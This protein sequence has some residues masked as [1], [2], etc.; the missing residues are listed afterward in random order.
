MGILDSIIGQA[1][2]GGGGTQT[3]LVNAVIGLINNQQTG[4]LAGLVKQF[5]GLGLGDI[6]N[7]WVSTGKNLPV[8][9]QQIQQG[10]G[11]DAI[12]QLAAKVGLSPQDLTLHLSNVL[13]Q[14]VDKL[15]PDGKIPQGDLM[16]KGMSILEGLMK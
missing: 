11:S 6:V 9:P 12:S 8:T 5:A 4:G 14:V 15:T 10:L 3:L 16:S 13:P 1:S 7:S 2:G